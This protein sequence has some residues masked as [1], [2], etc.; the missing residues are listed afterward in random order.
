[1]DLWDRRNDRVAGFSKGMKQRLA[2]ARALLNNPR[3]LIMD[4]PLSG[5]DPESHR[6]IVD[7]V[8]DLNRNRGVTVFLTSHSLLDAEELCSR[9]A[10]LSKGRIVACD[11]IDKLRA[12]RPVSL[13]DFKLPAGQ[14]R[15]AVN[16]ML[17]H[18]KGVVSYSWLS[19]ERLQVEIGKRIHVFIRA[20]C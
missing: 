1:M 15:E 10:V 2:I 8:R 13:V 20:M 11:R 14:N 4:E 7:L 12:G 16:E 19:D 18:I 9:V 5:L 6:R 3:L 17:E